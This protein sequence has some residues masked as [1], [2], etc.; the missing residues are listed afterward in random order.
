MAISKP[1]KGTE[2]SECFE[3]DLFRSPIPQILLRRIFFVYTKWDEDIQENGLR[4]FL[5]YFLRLPSIFLSVLFDIPVEEVWRKKRNLLYWDYL[6]SREVECVEVPCEAPRKFFIRRMGDYGYILARACF[7]FRMPNKKI[8]KYSY[9]T[10]EVEK[11]VWE[12]CKQCDCHECCMSA[13][14]D[15]E[16]SRSASIYLHYR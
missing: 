4:P 2:I 5:S 16:V 1:Y 14:L 8:K 15:S 3:M 6:Y 9:K 7:D 12:I 13:F 10:R 11:W